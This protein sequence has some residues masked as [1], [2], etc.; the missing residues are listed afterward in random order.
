MYMA[1]NTPPSGGYPPH[2]TVASFIKTGSCYDF[3]HFPVVGNTVSTDLGRCAFR[4]WFACVRL[5][6]GHRVRVK[7]ALSRMTELGA[8]NNSIYFKSAFRYTW[9]GYWFRLG[10]LLSVL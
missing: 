1:Y 5:A 6:C 4:P 10:R 8:L 3:L 9:R 2:V 7:I